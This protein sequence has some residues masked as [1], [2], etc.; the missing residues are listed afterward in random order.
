MKLI[1]FLCLLLP[2]ISFAQISKETCKSYNV[3]FEDI[4][5]QLPMQVDYTTQLI[6]LNTM[7]TNKIC[8]MH[9]EY[10]V[11]EKVF[12]ENMVKALAKNN[13]ETSAQEL[14]E[15]YKTS[16]GHKKLQDDFKRMQLKR[17]HGNTAMETFL[18]YK[19]VITV[20]S[21]FSGDIPNL[22]LNIK[23]D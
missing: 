10:L 17:L 23:E 3:E 15:F 20:T 13:I 9:Y 2:T 16:N 4:N 19:G 1:L 7:Y 12:L 6:G 11:S 22:T 21:V 8:Y 5:S 14:I 18:K